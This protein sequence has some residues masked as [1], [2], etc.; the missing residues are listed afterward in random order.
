[1]NR[2]PSR[3]H[4]LGLLGAL[5]WGLAGA[6]TDLELQIGEVTRL[7]KAAGPDPG[8]YLKRGDLYR[9]NGDWT[10]AEEDFNAVRR[11]SPD[12][13]LTDWFHGR[14]SVEAGRPAKGDELLS[15]FLKLNPGHG[16]AYRARGVARWNLKQPLRAAHDY[17]NAI[18]NSERASP[19]LFRSLVL[20]L[21]AAGTEHTDSASEAVNR[22]LTRFPREVSLLGLGADL[23]LVKGNQDQALGYMARLPQ[24]LLGLP[25]WQFRRAVGS[26]IEGDTDTA[27]RGFLAILPDAGNHKAQRAGTWEI[28]VG[29]LMDLAADP[30]APSCRDAAW[31]VL[32]RQYP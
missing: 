22:G 1:M 5:A 13:P 9:R 26:C 27:A 12:H 15:R 8:L 24:R 17:Q 6:H 10:L 14:L 21:V 30:R 23:A 32:R 18:D 19:S 20:S 16:A 28:P 7:M 25:Q 3:Q 2:Y 11:L 29:L 4:W 31:E